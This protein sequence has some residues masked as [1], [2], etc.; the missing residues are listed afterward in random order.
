MINIALALKDRIDSFMRAHT[1]LVVPY[2][3][4]SN[5]AELYVTDATYFNTVFVISFQM[6]C[7]FNFFS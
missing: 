3:A 5:P 2:T 4:N 6:I 7:I 1:T